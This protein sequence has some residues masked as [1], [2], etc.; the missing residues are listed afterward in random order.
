MADLLVGR[1]G[2]GG[3]S[4]VK[5]LPLQHPPCSFLCPLAIGILS[6][7]LWVLIYLYLFVAVGC[8]SE[9]AGFE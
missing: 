1:S 8:S 6:N 7:G 4:R 2:G 3:A 5:R 9:I